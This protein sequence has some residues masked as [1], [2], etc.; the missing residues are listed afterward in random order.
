MLGRT[1]GLDPSMHLHARVTSSLGPGLMMAA[2]I[3][4]SGA[5]SL[6]VVETLLE[7]GPGWTLALGRTRS[8]SLFLMGGMQLHYYQMDGGEADSRY[9]WSLSLPL[10]IT[11]KL[12]RWRLRL[13]LAPGI[14]GMKRS[15][16]MDGE[17]LWERS[18]TRIGAMLGLGYSS[19]GSDLRSEEGRG[20]KTTR[21]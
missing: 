9:D 11:Q 15:H 19:G 13:A 7:A 3:I 18:A 1:G 6:S 16:M 10:E 4:P 17:V 21:R 2:A 20:W 5:R 12:H 8:L 14:T